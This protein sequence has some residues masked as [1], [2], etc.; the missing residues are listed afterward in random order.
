MMILIV[1][2]AILLLC[3][4][5]FFNEAEP[6]LQ[7]YLALVCA[8]VRVKENQIKYSQKR[9]FLGTAYAGTDYRHPS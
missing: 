3:S 4:L 1:R 9:N 8:E 6:P 7:V 5:R 2:K